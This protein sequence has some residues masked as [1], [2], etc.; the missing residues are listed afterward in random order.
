MNSLRFFLLLCVTV[1]CLTAGCSDN[2]SQAKKKGFNLL[3]PDKSKGN[4]ERLPRKIEGDAARQIIQAIQQ[5]PQRKD[6]SRVVRHYG[7]FL[8]GLAVVVAGLVYWQIW[9]RKRKEWEL[10]DPMALVQELNSVH[11]LSD[12]EK[13]LMQEITA[14]NSLSSPLKL[15]VEPRFLFEALEDDSFSSFRP[16][17]QLLLSKLF[18]ATADDRS[19]SAVS[20]EMNTETL[21]YS[22]STQA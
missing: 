5:E 2:S 16:T 13:R 10:N 3:N 14:Q 4:T 8:A 15:F 17:V 18:D 1:L 9:R 6:P 21:Y 22:Q 11:Q 12:K 20:E 19:S 7:T